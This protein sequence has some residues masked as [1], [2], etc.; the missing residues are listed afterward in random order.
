VRAPGHNANPTNANPTTGVISF[1]PA[2][3]PTFGNTVMKS[4]HLAAINFTGST[5]CVL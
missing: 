5:K 4:E 3:G 1:L 2:D